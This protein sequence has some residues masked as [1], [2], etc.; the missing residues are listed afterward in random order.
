[1]RSYRED[2]AYINDAG[3]ADFTDGV[4]PGVLALLRRAGIAGGLVVDLGCGAGRWA[5]ALGEAGYEVLGIDQSPAMIRMARRRAPGARFRTGSVLSAGLPAC[6]A[7]TSIGEVVNYAFD[8]AHSRAAL[9]A[10]FRRVHAALRPGGLFV[11]DVAGPERVPAECP[12]S[13]RSAGE[14]WEIDVEVDG[15]ARSGWMT[16]KIVCRREQASGKKK[17]SRE[18]HRLRLFEKEDIAAELRGMGFAVRTQSRYGQFRL[19]AGM[20]AMVARKTGR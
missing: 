10:L 7:V 20:H 1:M 14:G 4:T 3:F 18:V 2:L 19:Y 8:L 11:F 12:Q 17:R 16:R 5:A 13:Y 9:S 15:C 6:D